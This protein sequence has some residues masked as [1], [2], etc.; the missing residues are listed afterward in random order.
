MRSVYI[1]FFGIYL[2]ALPVYAQYADENDLARSQQM[3]EEQRRMDD[4]K[5]QNEQQARQLAEQQQQMQEQQHIN[6]LRQS[7]PMGESNGRWH[8]N[9]Y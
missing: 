8:G 9:G 4:M 7:D 2:L 6:D 3:Q 5:Y 1:V